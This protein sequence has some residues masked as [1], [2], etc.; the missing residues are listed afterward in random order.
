MKNLTAHSKHDHETAH[1]HMHHHT[2]NQNALLISFLIIFVFMIVEAVGGYL[3]GSLALISDAGHMLSDAVSLGMSFTAILIGNRASANNRKTFGYKRFEILAALFNG[4]LLFLISIWIII[5]AIARI[6]QPVTIASGEMMIIAFIGLIVNVIVAKILMQ[7]EKN[8]NLNVRSAFLHVLGDLLGSVGAIAASALIM[9]F[10]WG[11]ADPIASMIVSVIILKSGWS[12]TRDSI[13]VLM[14][15][16]PDNLDLDEIRNRMT[17]LKGVNG[18]HDLH[19]WT[20]TSGFFSLSCHL[21][22][23]E[24]INHDEILRQVEQLLAGY[25]LDHSTIQIESVKFQGCHSDCSHQRHG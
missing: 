3:S 19:I 17:T 15:A 9:F 4:V 10:G 8:D 7:G 24:G 2:T 16:K 22:V 14:E 18:I 21:T 1:S 20:I 11:I 13:N 5:E 12:V 25:H 6:A 23:E